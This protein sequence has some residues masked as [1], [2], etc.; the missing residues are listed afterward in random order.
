MA[1]ADNGGIGG[2][3]RVVCFTIA[4]AGAGP[5]LPALTLAALA[6]GGLVVAALFLGRFASP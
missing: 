4:E 1:V 5:T 3:N 2:P 6:A